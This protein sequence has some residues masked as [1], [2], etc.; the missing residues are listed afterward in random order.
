MRTYASPGGTYVGV[1]FKGYAAK[2][3]TVK[4]PGV[5]AGAVLKNLVT[6][7]TVPLVTDAAGAHFEVA[8]GPME[9]N[10]YLLQ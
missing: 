4:L 3:L 8:T 1:A 2:A 9:L 7:A 10:A 6:G 5:K